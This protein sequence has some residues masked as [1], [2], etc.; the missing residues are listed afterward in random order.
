M[1]LRSVARDNLVPHITQEIV[2]N[3]VSDRASQVRVRVRGV[4]MEGRPVVMAE[5]QCTEAS[6][7]AP[8][9]R[10]GEA[11]VGSEVD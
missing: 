3:T 11:E 4:E 7:V 6:Q 5:I 10:A 9:L 2:H 8:L 1:S